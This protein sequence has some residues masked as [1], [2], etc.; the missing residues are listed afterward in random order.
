MSKT[1]RHYRDNNEPV[2]PSME[3]SWSLSP[4][5]MLGAIGVGVGLLLVLGFLNWQL[6]RQ[7]QANVSDR[8]AQ[9][10]NRLAQLSTKVEQ[11]GT[12]AGPTTRGPDPNRIY[13][14]KTDGAPVK[15]PMDAPITIAEFSD[16]Q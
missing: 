14:I 2:V 5:S 10:E 8:L 7:N 12:R 9:I 4:G 11:A 1:A 6:L 13:T 15:G 3:R 16:Y